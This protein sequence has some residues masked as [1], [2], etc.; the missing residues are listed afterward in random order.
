MSAPRLGRSTIAV[1]GSPEPRREGEP[2]IPPIMQSSTFVNA[3]GSD[4]EVRYTRY[5]NNPNQVSL[6]RKYAMLEGAEDAVFVASGMGATAL[7]HLA[8]LRP[9]DH[10]LASRWIYGG[11]LK[12]FD[13]EFGRFGIT[14][15]YVDPTTP[16]IWR[17]SIK[18]NTR[19][20]FIES[21]VNPTIRVLDLAPIASIA[22]EF[23][24][25]LLVDSTFAS[26][27][28]FR[29]L[30][31]G[32]DLVITSATKYLNGHTDVIAGA[33]AG[34]RSVI[35]EVIR[36]M[37]VWGQ[38]I[39]PHAAWLLDRGMRTLAIR[40]ERH[41][42][43]G[44]AVAAFLEGHKGVTA[45]TYPG[46]ESHPDHEIAVRTL[47]GFGGMVGLQLKGGSTAVDRFLRRLR[48]FV[49][50]PSL[51]GVESLVSDPRITSH[52]GQSPAMLESAGIGEGFVR[53]SCGIEDP[54]DLIADLEQA[55]GR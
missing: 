54:E 4:R 1:H 6:A 41:N 21:P 45:V 10:L 25:A 38:A 50:A 39:D 55:L 29:P 33:V 11:T 24:L 2:V 14:V 3:V 12:L 34:T 28:N 19:A 42:R 32:A 53:L 48:L 46:L 43:N 44:M 22:K 52:K 15:S 18:K 51:A 13:E 36:L 26:P 23:G 16:R 20:L 40:M 17:K 8:V 47:D 5:G 9:G 37:R 49:H 31:Q 30:E 7:A 35:E 27:I